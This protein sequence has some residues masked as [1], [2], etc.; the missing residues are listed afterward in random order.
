MDGFAYS[1][2]TVSQREAH[3]QAFY[4]KYLDTEAPRMKQG[5]LRFPFRVTTIFVD[6]KRVCT[7][8]YCN[9]VA[10]PPAIAIFSPDA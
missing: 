6:M 10:P 3:R 1:K 9:N 7:C 5:L 4:K 2:Y 8:L